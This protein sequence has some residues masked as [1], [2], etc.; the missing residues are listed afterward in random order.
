MT[1]SACMNISN[2]WWKIFKYCFLTGPLLQI[3][4]QFPSGVT[5]L[6]GQPKHVKLFC[7]VDTQQQ[8]V[9]IE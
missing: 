6:R 5:E 9:A 7:T 8:D 1:S 2:S 4:L 3:W